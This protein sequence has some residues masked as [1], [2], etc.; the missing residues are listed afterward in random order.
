[1]AR[2]ND[3]YTYNSYLPAVSELISEIN[4]GY[5]FNIFQIRFTD[6]A[7][8]MAHGGKGH[9]KIGFAAH[10]LIP[11]RFPV[12]PL[13]LAGTEYVESFT[14]YQP[15]TLNEFLN[16]PAFGMDEEG[17]FSFP[18]PFNMDAR[19]ENKY[20]NVRVFIE[21]EREFNFNMPNGGMKNGGEALIFLDE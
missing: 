1:M 8:Q 7:Q 11:V 19:G 16:S 6:Y 21:D 13:N 14:T 17:V 4:L 18:S 20:I 9:V 2:V 12:I 10:S 15:T 3:L 5:N